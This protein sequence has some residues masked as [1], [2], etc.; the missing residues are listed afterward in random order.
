MIV[1]NLM[2][3][4]NNDHFIQI[5]YETATHGPTS[6]LP[7]RRYLETWDAHNA[8]RFDS[9]GACLIGALAASA[10]GIFVSIFHEYYTPLRG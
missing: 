10:A 6:N 8:W 1:L 2:L 3:Q 9:V 7:P 5:C 4:L